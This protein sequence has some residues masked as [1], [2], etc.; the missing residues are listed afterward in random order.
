[1]RLCLLVVSLAGCV[2]SPPS[3]VDDGAD[4]AAPDAALADSLPPVEKDAAEPDAATFED[5]ALEDAELEAD[6]SEMDAEP[7]DAMEPEDATPE[8]ATAPDRDGDGIPDETDACPDDPDNDAD[9]DG[10]CAGEDNCPLVS[11]PAQEDPNNDGVGLACVPWVDTAFRR[12]KLLI[13]DAAQVEAPGGALADYPVLIS[14]VDPEMSRA[15]RADG[16]D[17]FF[18]DEAARLDHEIETYDGTSGRLIAWVRIPA[19]SSTVDTGVYVYYGNPSSPD[20]SRATAVWDDGFVGVWH[21]DE[22]VTDESSTGMHADS[23]MNAHGAV[24]SGNNDAAGEIDLAQDFD[25]TNDFAEVG[26]TPELDI[27]GDITVEAWIRA[28]GW[29]S[30]SF[31]GA[32]VDKHIWSNAI[33]RGYVLRAGDGGRASFNIGTGTAWRDALS[34]RVMSLATWHYV[35]GRYDGNTVSIFVDGTSRA[36]VTSG[37]GIGGSSTVLRLGRG[38]YDPNRIFDGRIDEVRISDVARSSEWIRTTYNNHAAPGLGG[39]LRFIGAEETAP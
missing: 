21:L 35:V 10:I 6:A 12:R 9:G 15:A 24:Q 1:V 32:I 3:A 37:G 8:D 16:F 4:R 30:D 31:G 14:I 38:G 29:E 22:V 39:F 13:I 33:E 18:T 2:F 34:G 28:D 19:L 27:T 20:Q 7:F 23:T 11:N 5:A 36:G 17:I 26:S 25:G